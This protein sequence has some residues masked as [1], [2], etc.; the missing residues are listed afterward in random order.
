MTLKNNKLALSDL[1]TDSPNTWC[2]GCGNFGIEVAVKK[3]FF[4]LIE[5]NKVKRENLVIA[6]GI[7]CHGKITDYLNINSFYSL[8]GRAIAPATGIKLARPELTVTVMAGDG[9]TYSEGLSHLMFAAKRNIDI[10]VII[11]DN[12]VYGLTA[13]QVSPTSPEGFVGTTTPDGS[14]DRPINPLELMINTGATFVAR[15]FSAD[16][17]SLKETIKKAVN[18]KG[19]SFVE[20]LQPCF[21]FFNTYDHYRSN[22]YRLENKYDLADKL[23]ALEKAREWDYSNATS[24]I[25]LGVFYQSKQVT[26]DQFIEMQNAK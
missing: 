26:F 9:D 16:A 3:A 25:P 11:H 2:P 14:F 6:T 20:V 17:E 22:T 18:H 8:H 23:M 21:T 1:G 19:F 15:A 4:E 10:T 7:G 24:K 5:E 12:R 13:K